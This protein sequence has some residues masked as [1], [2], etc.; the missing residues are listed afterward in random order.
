MKS[1][2][3]AGGRQGDADELLA[4]RL[5]VSLVRV[6]RTIK[7]VEREVWELPA[8]IDVQKL[9]ARIRRI[10]DW[11]RPFPHGIEPDPAVEIAI[12]DPITKKVR[13]AYAHS[14]AMRILQ[15]CLLLAVRE[16]A[17]AALPDNCH[18]YR[19]GHDRYTALANVQRNIREGFHYVLPVDVVGYFDNCTAELVLPA[20][21]LQPW[22]GKRMRTIAMW[23]LRTP[24]IRR[25]R[26]GELI[27]PTGHP[28]RP[29]GH[30]LQGAPIAAWLA[31]VVGAEF[32]DKPMLTMSEGVRIVR[33]S[34][35]IAI[36]GG[37]SADCLRGLDDLR[38]LLG[39]AGLALHDRDYIPTD[40]YRYP[41]EWLGRILH[42]TA[43]R[44]PNEKVNKMIAAIAATSTYSKEKPGYSKE[45]LRRCAEAREELRRDTHQRERFEYIDRKL[46]QR[47]ARHDV[48]FAEIAKLWDPNAEP[49]EEDVTMWD[50]EEV[51]AA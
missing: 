40:V 38:R 11:I 19:R 43:I 5:G 7:G 45:C 21:E 1:W 48:V 18:A 6:P 13:T 46:R 39:G 35:N 15:R 29:A 25:P 8:H 42:G 49:P 24:V 23:A 47:G 9:E 20:L 3:V 28:Y 14:Y 10:V 31:N 32:I 22:L 27:D 34:D 16:H 36:M 17:E 2:A 33:Y 12:K 41:V 37:T 51:S 4:E 26:P 50:A 44:T 30:L